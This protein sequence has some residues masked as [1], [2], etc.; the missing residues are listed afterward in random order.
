MIRIRVLRSWT[1]SSAGMWV[2][3]MRCS[4]HSAVGAWHQRQDGR[5]CPLRKWFVSASRG[6]KRQLVVC[7]ARYLCSSPDDGPPHS[8][9]TVQRWLI[10]LCGRVVCCFPMI[11]GHAFVCMGWF[12]RDPLAT[13]DASTSSLVLLNFLTKD[14]KQSL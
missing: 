9:A 10:P 1:P 13:F 4:P 8:R 14:K 12:S 2:Q 6:H 5:G 3:V 11:C 7:V